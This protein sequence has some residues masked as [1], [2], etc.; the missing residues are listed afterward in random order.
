MPIGSEF[1]WQVRHLPP[2]SRID[3]S[4]STATIDADFAKDVEA[5]IIA[6]RERL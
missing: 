3:A 2:T 6:H 1:H 4:R 5:A